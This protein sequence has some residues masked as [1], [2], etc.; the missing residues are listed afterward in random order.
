MPDIQIGLSPPSLLLKQLG[1]I[2]YHGIMYVLNYFF[3]TRMTR[4][5]VYNQG[6]MSDNTFYTKY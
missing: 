3:S 5:R 4:E 2:S 6:V 1:I